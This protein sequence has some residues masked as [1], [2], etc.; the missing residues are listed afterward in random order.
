MHFHN[1]GLDCEK[2]Y[3]RCFFATGLFYLHE[4]FQ[5]SQ[6]SPSH[7]IFYYIRGEIIFPAKYLLHKNDRKLHF[8]NQKRE[9]LDCETWN[10]SW[11]HKRSVVK[12]HLKIIFFTVQP[13]IVKMQFEYEN[14]CI[15]N[16][17]S[18]NIWAVFYIIVFNSSPKFYSHPA[19]RLLE[20]QL[21]FCKSSFCRRLCSTR[22]QI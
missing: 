6:S 4:K 16:H 7:G 19:C 21:T 20:L 18:P 9:G 13:F 12:K 15:L 22:T 3:L 5:L 14:I 8:L 1:E 11:R 17:S 2:N 10:F